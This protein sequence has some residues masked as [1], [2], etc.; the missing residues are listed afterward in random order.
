MVLLKHGLIYFDIFPLYRQRLQKPLAV[1]RRYCVTL[2][3]LSNYD[4]AKRKLL[5]NSCDL[6]ALYEGTEGTGQASKAM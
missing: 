4:S 5:S 6:L 2:E 3:S 1:R